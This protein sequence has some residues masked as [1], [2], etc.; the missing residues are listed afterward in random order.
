V[1]P[2][3]T[4]T[5]FGC[6]LLLAAAPFAIRHRARLGAL[7]RRFVTEPDGPFNLA[8]F[9]IVFFATVPIFAPDLAQVRAL[10]ALP[11][12]LLV[13]PWGL[14]PVLGDLRSVTAVSVAH[15]LL[16]GGSVTACLG[17][18]TRTSA[19]V[20]TLSGVYYLGLAELYGKVNHFH[21]L[22]WLSAIF[23]VS[24]SGDALSLD[25]VIRAVRGRSPHGIGPPLRSL[26]YS[27]PLRF[28]WILLGIVYLFPGFW[29]AFQLGY[30]WLEPSTL[31][32]HL[33]QKWYELGG[34]RPPVR[35][36]Q[37][38]ALLVAGALATVLFELGFILLLFTRR[39]RVI[40]ALAGLGFHNSTAV[41]MKISFLSLQAVYVSLIDWERLSRRMFARRGRAPLRFVFDGNCGI[42][43]TTVSALQALTLPGS[44]VFSNA[45]EDAAL[46]AAGTPPVDR[47]TLLADIH[48]WDGRRWCVG[49]F[50]YRRLARRVPWLWPVLPLLYLP[51][52]V[53]AGTRV[54]RH[55]AD[56]RACAVAPAARRM[57]PA[58]VG[59]SVSAVACV[60]SLLVAA[61]VAAGVTHRRNAWPFAH[62]PDFAY[63]PGDEAEVLVVEGRTVDGATERLDLRRGMPAVSSPTSS[64]LVRSIVA[65]PS[66]AER[67]AD[68]AAFM[69][70][71]APRDRAGRPYAAITV[72]QERVSVRPDQD[73]RVLARGK[74]L[75]MDAPGQT[76]SSGR[77]TRAASPEP[78]TRG[79]TGR[80]S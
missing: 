45:L 57:R 14:G 18:L 41:M 62:Y 67:R 68:L 49:Y 35:I 25:A 73:G 40:A 30:H 20:V 76:A 72:W 4:S 78:S 28:T 34:Y 63:L 60:G 23:A 39:T 37:V 36:D 15:A 44:V 6:I 42:C 48:L 71:A 74:V 59:R 80:T 22:V 52:V 3:V 13:P 50:A 8:V 56:H 46:A 24:R 43:R 58:A 19:A 55:V 12:R 54:Y 10:T 69:R 31:A 9:R 64:G 29:K 65:R 7:L 21:H 1:G 32:S 61:T 77:T 70:V 66:M 17:L 51:P 5:I 26:A 47:T 11:E 38:P 79:S 53:W 33:W 75:R 27:L 2:R 16:V